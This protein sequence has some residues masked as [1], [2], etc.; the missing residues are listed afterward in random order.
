MYMRTPN[1]L[2]NPMITHKQHLENIR[3]IELALAEIYGKLLAL[4]EQEYE[5]YNDWLDIKHIT[6]SINEALWLK[7]NF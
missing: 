1:S 4:K 6:E 3:E 5:K 2:N 7:N